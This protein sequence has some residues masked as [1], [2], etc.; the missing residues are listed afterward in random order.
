MR[1]MS[2]LMLHVRRLILFVGS[3]KMLLLC[4][5]CV[6]FDSF[7]EIRYTSLDMR[8]ADCANAEA[9]L[10]DDPRGGKEADPF[11]CDASSRASR[12]KSAVRSV[13]EGGKEAVLLGQGSGKRRPGQRL[14]CYNTG[15]A[16]PAPSVGKLITVDENW[17]FA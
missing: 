12:T 9:S 15:S 11:D 6:S 4:T 5:I 14:S 2:S 7:C 3:L 8:D 10:G 16:F 13:I 1:W 17:F